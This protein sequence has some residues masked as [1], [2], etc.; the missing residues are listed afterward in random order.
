MRMNEPDAVP[1]DL[2]VLF[3]APAVG[4]MTVGQELERE[5]GYRLFH[6]HQVL[7]LVRRYF[8]YSTDAA[9]PYERLVVA[10]RRLFFEE[11]A[12]S[13][14][15]VVT[16]A[17]WRFDLPAEESAIRS[18]MQPFLDCGR[19]VCFV[20]LRASLETRLTRNLTEN[21]R[22]HKQ[23]DWSTEDVLR[24]DAAAHSY[25]SGG[26][27][28]F[29]APLLQVETDGYSAADVAARIRNRFQIPRWPDGS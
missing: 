12:R 20:E 13:G 24:A 15:R 5:T 14:L 27:L 29:D 22:R 4:K 10:Y 19:R 28:P 3:G 9:S 6:L 16:T 21:R 8:P 11:A 2:I 18:Y 7:D 1:P 17:G 23:V 25:D 26:H